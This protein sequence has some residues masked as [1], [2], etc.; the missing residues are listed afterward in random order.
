MGQPP[1]SSRPRP[2]QLHEWLILPELHRVSGHGQAIQ[3][4]PRLIDVLVYLA[5]HAGRVIT[6]DELMDAVWGEVIVNEESLTRAISELRRILRDDR[7]A[8]RF[9]ETIRKTG[10]RLVAPV[11]APAP[12]VLSAATAL[13]VP[14][15]ATAPGVPSGATAPASPARAQD[16]RTRLR[17]IIPLAFG[18]AAVVIAILLLRPTTP[19]APIEPLVLT[20]VPFTTYTGEETRPAISSDGTRV[21]FC[22]G[23]PEGENFD[24]YVKQRN[25]EIPLR[26]TDDLT[27]E[28]NP[29]WSPDGTTI[30][31]VRRLEQGA[32]IFTVPAIGGVPRRLYLG[33]HWIPGIDWSPDGKW[34]AFAER[35]SYGEQEPPSRIQL[36]SLETLEARPLTI[37][38]PGYRGDTT[39]AFSPDGETLAFLRADDLGLLDLY[40]MPAGGGRPRRLTRGGIELHGFD[41]LPDGRGLV[42]SSMSTGSLSLWRVAVAGGELLPLITFAD[43]AANP[44][45]ASQTGALVYEDIRFDSNIFRVTLSPGEDPLHEADPFIGSTHWDS[46]PEYSPDGSRIVFTSKRTGE[47]EIW[48]CRAD[49]SRPEQLTFFEGPLVGR[50]SWSPDGTRIAFEAG[51]RGYANAYVVAADG[52]TARAVTS[53]E[54]NDLILGWSHDG[55]WLYLASDRTTD[56]DGSGQLWRHE[57]DGDRA[58]RLAISACVVAKEAADG[59][60]L[61]FARIGE[62]E[63]W[64]MPI[65]G[66]EEEA[67]RLPIALEDI[68]NW[69]VRPEGILYVELSDAGPLVKLYEFE[70]GASRLLGQLPGLCQPGLALSPDGGTL[71]YART[72]HR[73][74]DIAVCDRLAGLW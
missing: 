56:R 65:D 10:Y 36:L 34:I 18:A 13:G 71:L 8:P 54:H 28:S 61:F 33:E 70:S 21:A 69:A 59:A 57:V 12:G 2:F 24:I 45:I 40:L 32:G 22:W 1:R 14:S 29:A 26:L 7:S 5:D 44:S 31:F 15:A 49:G 27:Y 63:L 48:L 16:L 17:R 62:P 47:R 20:S 35:S 52:G 73:S 3:V 38:P 50:P 72:D 51:P 55:I 30:A 11:V 39:P 67:E 53:D 6:R 46:E 19:R 60:H 42:I 68:S 74:V 4:E 41:W 58:E 43:W 23:G 9:I 37:P 66:D 64:R 25:T